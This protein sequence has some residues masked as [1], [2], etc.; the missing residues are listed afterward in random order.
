MYI[1]MVSDPD[2]PFTGSHSTKKPFSLPL[3]LNLALRF[4]TVAKTEGINTTTWLSPPDPLT[5]KALTVMRYVWPQR[6]LALNFSFP[7]RRICDWGG[8]QSWQVM[9]MWKSIWIKKTTFL[10]EQG[11]NEK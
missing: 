3:F 7:V 1:T 5:T 2:K 11:R 4:L 8:L 6:S 9:F 10:I